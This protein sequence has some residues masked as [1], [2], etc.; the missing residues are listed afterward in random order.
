MRKTRFLRRT[1]ELTVEA[2]TCLSGV[3]TIRLG[4]WEG[5]CIWTTEERWE[6]VSVCPFDPDVTPSWQDMCRLKDI[7]FEDED[8]VLQM[9][10]PKSQYVNIM[11]NCLHLWKPRD[12]SL[13]ALLGENQERQVCT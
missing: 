4:G 10:P 11:N 13:L 9:H 3:G 7:F 6:H 5:S 2:A 1:E 8:F 12:P